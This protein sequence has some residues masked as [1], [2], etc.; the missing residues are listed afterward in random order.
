MNSRFV[1]RRR[2][3]R[4]DCEKMVVLKFGGS[5]VGQPE[6]FKTAIAIVKK[7]RES[8]LQPV[9]IASALSGVTDRLVQAAY[10]CA[11]TTFDQEAFSQW[12]RDR[13]EKHALAVLSKEAAQ[14]FRDILAEYITSIQDILESLQVAKEE[15]TSAAEKD[16][17]LAVGERLSV[18]LF[19]LALADAG[20][21]AIP[22]DADL[23]T[24]VRVF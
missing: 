2:P 23:D 8:G 12:I 3:H 19:A 7:Y 5:S 21:P 10:D 17:L 20:E 13:H 16:A 24:V 14:R 4:F 18:R 22:V 11:G 1:S 6:R 9:I 15:S